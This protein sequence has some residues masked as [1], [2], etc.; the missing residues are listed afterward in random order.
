MYNLLKTHAILSIIRSIEAGISA[1]AIYFGLED[2]YCR[3]G[4]N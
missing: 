2:E 4:G 1:P 3:T